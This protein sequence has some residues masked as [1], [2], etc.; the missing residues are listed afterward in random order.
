MAIGVHIARVGAFNI[1][2][3]GNVIKKDDPDVTIKQQ[4]V[5]TLEHRVIADTTI[6]NSTSNPTVKTYLELEAGNDFVLHYMD[7]NSI[8]TYLR[9]AAGGFG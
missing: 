7:Q 4:L 9:T 5:T 1:D 8:I 3:T 2:P 6:A